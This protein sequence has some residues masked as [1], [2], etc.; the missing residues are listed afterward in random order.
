MKLFI[1]KSRI[2]LTKKQ[3]EELGIKINFQGLEEYLSEKRF[4]FLLEKINDQEILPQQ[5]ETYYKKLLT[6]DWNH[7]K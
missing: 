2:I 7:I 1:D 5:S 4:S 3:V 6:K